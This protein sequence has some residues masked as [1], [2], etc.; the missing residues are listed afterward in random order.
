MKPIYQTVINVDLDNATCMVKS[1]KGNI[2]PAGINRLN[3]T[4]NVG[5][6]ALVTKSLSGEWIVIDVEHKHPAPL[7]VHDFPRDKHG[8]L[9]HIAYC[10]YRKVIED[11]PVSKRISFDNYLRR[12][13]GYETKMVEPEQAS[14]ED[15]V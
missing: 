14:L 5:D 4:I 6:E 8:D 3:K 12:K 13:Y 2:Y 15:Y 7:T 11:M 1:Q 10:Q 9:N